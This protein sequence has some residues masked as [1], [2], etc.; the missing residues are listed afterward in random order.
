MAFIEREQ[1]FGLDCGLVDMALLA[2]TLIT[3]DARLWTRDQ[4]LAVLARRFGVAYTQSD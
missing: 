4:R 1:L 3:P 2:S